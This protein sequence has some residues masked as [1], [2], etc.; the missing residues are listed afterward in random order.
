MRYDLVVI[1]N[2]SA[3]QAGALAAVRMNKRVALVEQCAAKV[4]KG[5][6][7]IAVSACVLRDAVRQ[8]ASG[9]A[10]VTMRELK[11]RVKHLADRENYATH[12]RLDRG[13][14][15]LYRGCARFTRPREIIVQTADGQARLE[16]DQV[17]I[18]CGTKPFRPKSIPFDG[19]RV[20]DVDELLGLEEL[21]SSLLIVGAGRTGIEQ[22]TLLATLGVSVTVVDGGDRLLEM[23]DRDIAEIL[24]SRARSLG[25]TFRL[26]KDVI[27]V[28][29]VPG[30]PI[31]V[32]FASG[33]RLA[34]QALLYT[35]GRIGATEGLDLSAV[36]LETD[37]RGRLWC[38]ENQRTWASHVYGAGDVVG[39][40]ALAGTP[41]EQGRRAVLHAFGQ[42]CEPGIAAHRVLQTVPAT[43]MIG[44]TGDQLTRERIPFDARVLRT[45][46][47]SMELVAAEK[48][49]VIKLLFHAGSRQLLGVHT[50]GESASEIV[51]VAHGVMAHDGTLGEF[52]QRMAESPTLSC[53]CRG[54]TVDSL[55]H[56]RLDQPAA[57]GIGAD[58]HLAG[59]LA[60]DGCPEVTQMVAV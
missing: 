20:F 4:G 24:M 30:E 7:P 42:S 28:D 23:F 5:G 58:P 45:R 22:A 10:P 25:V 17:L 53:H 16:A 50:L 29:N 26:G 9:C 47:H 43:A 3:A 36:G 38:D 11:R 60:S 59:A 35:A 54:A 18:A 44:K 40:P 56:W 15:D 14:V 48:N 1:G 32:Y 12:D 41:G 21:P 31:K 55:P 6:A 33:E 8:V 49:D 46:N 34:G 52:C 19:T 13:E 39:F 2:D 27:G 37:E 51:S 57:N